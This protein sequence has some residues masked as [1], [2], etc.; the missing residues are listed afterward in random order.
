MKNPSQRLPVLLA[1]VALTVS[2]SSG[3]SVEG[4]ASTGSSTEAAAPGQASPD[5]AA[6][7]RSRAEW[8]DRLISC[9]QEDGW[10]I[11]VTEEGFEVDTS[12]STDEALQ[13]SEAACQERIGDYPTPAPLTD[14]EI[15]GLYALYLQSARC[16]QDLG[17]GVNS[18]PSEE[19]Y[20]Q[21][22]RSSFESGT[23]PWSPYDNAREPGAFE[24]CPEPTLED[25]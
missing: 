11:T 5:R 10:S 2:C 25:L 14:E 15:E 6:E 8:T 9:L 23:P 21:Q 13:V 16:L 3:P 18:P 24:T 1:A 20:V 22:Y 19:L 7:G 12:G 4:P 17:I